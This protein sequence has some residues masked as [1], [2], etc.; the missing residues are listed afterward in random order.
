MEDGGRWKMAGDGRWRGS[1]AQ[2]ETQLDKKLGQGNPAEHWLFEN[3]LRNI[4]IRVGIL[5][6]LA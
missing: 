1:C 6:Q 3:L 5:K 2:P 4:E